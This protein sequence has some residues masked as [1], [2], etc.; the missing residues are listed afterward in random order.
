M[1][2]WMIRCTQVPIRF[3]NTAAAAASPAFADSAAASEADLKDF[4]EKTYD[5]DLAQTNETYELL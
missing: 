3:A 1:I 5:M 2:L 4:L